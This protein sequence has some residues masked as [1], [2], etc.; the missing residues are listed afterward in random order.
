M[1]LRFNTLAH[2]CSRFVGSHLA[3]IGIDEHATV[4]LLGVQPFLL[5]EED[6]GRTRAEGGD[7]DNQTGH[8]PDEAV[9][10]DEADDGSAHGTCRPVDV[11]ALDA[12]ELQRLL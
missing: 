6:E 7:E 2:C 10:E 4:L 12:H 1:V 3:G 5:L 8:E 9:G 11:A